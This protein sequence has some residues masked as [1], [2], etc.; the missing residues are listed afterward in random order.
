[1]P[2]N[3]RGS[4]DFLIAIRL[5][6]LVL[7]AVFLP[8]AFD[9][10]SAAHAEISSTPITYSISGSQ[11]RIRLHFSA[12]PHEDS[13]LYRY[14]ATWDTPPAGISVGAAVVN[15][16]VF[17]SNPDTVPVGIRTGFRSNP[18]TVPG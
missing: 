7:A 13:H 2:A 5:A 8:A 12:I 3:R 15:W 6:L 9:V 4:S 11:R 10:G 1:M 17:R 14:R 18:D 16:C